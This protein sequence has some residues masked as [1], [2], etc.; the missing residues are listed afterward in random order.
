[1]DLYQ[2]CRDGRTWTDN[3]NRLYLLKNKLRIEFVKIKIFL[4]NSQIN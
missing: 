3:F 1:M 2:C 4:F